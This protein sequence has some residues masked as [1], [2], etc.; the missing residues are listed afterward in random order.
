[1]VRVL[2]LLLVLSASHAAVSVPRWFGDNMVF[3]KN[4]EYGARSFINGRARPGEKVVVTFNGNSKFPA[5]A[6]A[7]GDW[8]VQFNSAGVGKGP[9]TVSITGEDGPALTAKNVMGGDVYFCS[10]QS[11]SKS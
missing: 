3:Q 4:D 9:G 11:N 8:E 1:M 2:A 10:G 5:V 7:N 6:D